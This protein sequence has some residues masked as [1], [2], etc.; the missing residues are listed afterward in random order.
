MRLAVLADIHGNLPALEAVLNDLRDEPV[1]GFIVAGDMVAGPN[2][3]EVV[4][5]LRELNAW[6]IRGNNDNYLLKFASGSAPDWWYTAQQWAF[7]RWCFQQTDPATLEFLRS[8]PEQRVLALP[9]TSAMR[10]LHGSPRDVSELIYPDRDLS[11]LDLALGMTAEPV[12]IFGHTH[13]AWQLLRN[14]RLTLNPGA[15][16][17]SLVKSAC[18]NYAVMTWQAGDWKAELREVKY[19]ILALRAS[20]HETGLLEAGGAFARAVLF[21]FENGANTVPAL[22]EHAYKLAANAGYPDCEF[23]PDEIWDQAANTFDFEEFL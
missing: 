12:L 15:V 21:D 4:E 8:L 19:D 2:S 10:V 13:E 1:D 22:V 17:G 9:G 18:A 20:F 14:G 11:L 16:S 5:R 6:M 3:D 23:V 7:T